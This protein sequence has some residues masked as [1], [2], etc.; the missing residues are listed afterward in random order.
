VSFP[1]ELLS[2]T[3][4]ARAEVWER[5]GMHRHCQPIQ[6][7]HGKPV[8]SAQVESSNWL[9]E[10]MVWSSGEAEL[11]TLRLADDRCVN[12]HY[13]LGSQDD[14]GALLDELLELLVNDRIPV[15]AVVARWPATLG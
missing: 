12:K 6:P 1:L 11:A 10:I 15:A 14:L 2:A 13:E 9:A 7:N 4:N 5:L 3:V 8:V